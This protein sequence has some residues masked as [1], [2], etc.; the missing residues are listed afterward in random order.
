MAKKSKSLRQKAL[1]AHIKSTSDAATDQLLANLKNSYGAK[2]FSKGWHTD[3][4]VRHPDDPKQAYT[5]EILHNIVPV[6]FTK[7]EISGLEHLL[8]N[9]FAPDSAPHLRKIAKKLHVRAARNKVKTAHLQAFH[10]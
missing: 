5:F 3:I 4:T 7:E 8:R 9:A 10:G 6:L 1:E 2:D